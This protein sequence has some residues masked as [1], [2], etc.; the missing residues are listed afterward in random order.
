MKIN[1]HLLTPKVKKL[2]KYLSE[3]KWI[4]EFYL[5]GGTAVALLF[6]HR[7]SNDLDFF[8]N[9]EFNPHAIISKLDKYGKWEELKTAED[10]I[11]GII[12]GVKISFFKI[13]YPFIRN[14]YN[15]GNIKIANEI[16]LGLMKLLAI[17][18]RGTKRDFIDLYILTGKVVSLADFLE[19]FPEKFG[20]W[21]YNLPHV[22]KSLGYFRE[23]ENQ[24][25]PHMYVDLDWETVKK[26]F[27]EQQKLLAGKFLME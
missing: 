14:P 11:N 10:T 19:L 23:A 17:S 26:F 20:K 12:N 1:A 21:K 24:K 15:F 25:K 9:Q 3:Q 13:P 2:F 6:G 22:I 16:D 4:S 27:S 18:D 7:I 8:T 5:A